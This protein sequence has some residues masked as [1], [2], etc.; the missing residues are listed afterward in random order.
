[1][2]LIKAENGRIFIIHDTIFSIVKYSW[3]FNLIEIIDGALIEYENI[4][5]VQSNFEMMLAELKEG[6]LHKNLQSI[7][8]RH[9]IRY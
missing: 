7:L 3:T 6:A 5:L 4:E 2:V 1:M 8:N 9:Q